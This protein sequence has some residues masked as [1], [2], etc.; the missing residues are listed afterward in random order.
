MKFIKFHEAFDLVNTIWE[1]EQI[2]K[3]GKEIKKLF[4]KDRKELLVMIVAPGYETN[5][6]CVE[7]HPMELITP[8]TNAAKGS[9]AK[10]IASC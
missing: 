3:I 6:K 2:K 4:W 7:C 5:K 8:N 1:K 9:A 10:H